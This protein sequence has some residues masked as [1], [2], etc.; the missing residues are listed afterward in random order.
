MVINKKICS[1]TAIFPGSCVWSMPMLIK[2]AAVCGAAAA[3]FSGAKKTA[4]KLIPRTTA[5]SSSRCKRCKGS[6]RA[7]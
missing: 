3:L 1:T 4:L 5:A 2:G 7:I 6:R